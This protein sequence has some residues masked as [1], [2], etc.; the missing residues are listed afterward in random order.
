MT[1]RAR[2]LRGRYREST[3]LSRTRASAWSRRTLATIKW[4]Q[5]GNVSWRKATVR[6]SLAS[7][8][9][10]DRRGAP[11]SSSRSPYRT[12]AWPSS[13]WAMAVA[14]TPASSVGPLLHHSPYRN[15]KRCLLSA[16][17]T[18]RSTRGCT[19]SW[20]APRADP[21]GACSP[22]RLRGGAG[23]LDGD[24]GGARDDVHLDPGFLVVDAARVDPRQG[25]RRGR[26][27]PHVPERLA[28]APAGEDFVDGFLAD[29]PHGRPRQTTTPQRRNWIR[30]ASARRSLVQ[31]G[32]QETTVRTSRTPGRRERRSRT[33]SWI[34][35]IHGHAV[36]VNVKVT[37][38][39][40]SSTATPW[41]R[42]MSTTLTGH[43]GSATSRRAARTWS[44][45]T[46][47]GPR[48]SI[49]AR[50]PGGASGG[51]PAAASPRTSRCP[52]RGA[53]T[54]PE[55]GPR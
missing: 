22:P 17:A 34:I 33:S 14:A 25:V 49:S 54:G 46:A 52:A 8:S 38:T 23:R 31:G 30:A 16:R 5:V 18:T 13:S 9:C 45:V 32:S 6:A 53:S 1:L 26:D 37:V 11:G 40:P 20:G 21:G 7:H 4:G 12:R 10:S 35:S 55:P 42:P 15:P 29:P 50:P 3:A 44:A 39:T 24:E 28:L 27:P 36:E 47:P 41:T 43:S 51:A 48:G 2:C 19:H